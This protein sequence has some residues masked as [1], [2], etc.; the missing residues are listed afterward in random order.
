VAEP[1]G[2]VVPAVFPRPGISEI[3]F[4]STMPELSVN[5]WLDGKL[6]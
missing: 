1:A 3:T 2:E 6:R 4:E 5:S